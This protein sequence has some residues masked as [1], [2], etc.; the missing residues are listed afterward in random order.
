MRPA[1]VSLV[2]LAL[3]TV[4]V[5]QTATVSGTQKATVTLFVPGTEKEPLVASII[6]SVST[7]PT[8]IPRG[9]Y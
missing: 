8:Q 2:G 9:S 6:G 3:A 4:S 7:S 5:A 1:S